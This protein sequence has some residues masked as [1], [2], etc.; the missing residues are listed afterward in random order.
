MP[1]AIQFLGQREVA[2]QELDLPVPA[3][4]QVR[5]RTL[6]SLIST[7]TE[8]ICYARKFDPGTHWDMWVQYPFSPGYSTVGLVEA[9]GDGVDGLQ[10]GDR[11]V[12][13]TPHAS[14]HNIAAAEV[15][16]VTVP[17]PDEEVAWFALAKIAFVGVYAANLNLGAR[18]VVVGAGPIGQ[19]ATRWCAAAGA[20]DIVVVDF[21]EGRLLLAQAGGATAT[22]KGG[23][24]EHRDQIMAALGG[25][26]P[27]VVI[28]ST[29]NAA[30]FADALRL[31]ANF[32]KVVILGDTGAPATQTLTS[33][34]ITR[35]IHIVG[36][37]DLHT[38]A[39]TQRWDNDRE[40]FRLYF[41]LVGT[42]RFPVG[43][44]VTHRFRPQQAQEAYDFATDHREDSM[45]IL[46]D[47]AQENA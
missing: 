9:L 27:E 7:G 33:D 43:G 35:G 24:G 25:N 20:S 1:Q 12:A 30:A 39:N 18:V 45:G 10:V 28:D 23:V 37:H 8:T 2:L 46:F 11:V 16:K 26:Q 34:V 14:H 19:M 40:I 36:A 38:R 6:C 41:R 15:A 44:M 42:G 3:P 31:V 17:L 32:G 4:G 47:W 21:V 22:V 5:V 13:R 29:G